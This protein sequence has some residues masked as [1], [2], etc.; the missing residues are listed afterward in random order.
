M[1]ARY[2]ARYLCRHK[3]CSKSIQREKSHILVLLLVHISSWHTRAYTVFPGLVSS[4]AMGGISSGLLII[5][6]GK[7]I[8]NI[9]TIVNVSYYVD[10]SRKAQGTLEQIWLINSSKQQIGRTWMN[11][12]EKMMQLILWPGT[13]QFQSPPWSS[14]RSTGQTFFSNRC[15]VFERRIH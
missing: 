11:P 5:H 10:H 15:D 4:R 9:D 8:G 3:L 2:H 14:P 6:Q 13:T 1:T 12:R 7:F